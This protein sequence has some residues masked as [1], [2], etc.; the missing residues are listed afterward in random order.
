[1]DDELVNRLIEFKHNGFGIGEEQQLWLDSDETKV[2]IVAPEDRKKLYTLKATNGKRNYIRAL[3]CKPILG[4]EIDG[5]LNEKSQV[6][7]HQK[8]CRQAERL[9]ASYGDRIVPVAWGPHIHSNFGIT[10]E[11]EGVN[12][13]GFV[14]GILG[15]IKE[16]RIPLIQIDFSSTIDRAI[17]TIKIRIPSLDALHQLTRRLQSEN[18]IL[19]IRVISQQTNSD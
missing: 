8:S 13:D 19:H 14:Y 16:L 9:K 12:Q 5:I 6:E 3:C 1:M 11:I 18:D 10:L 7:V 17:G 2:P 4:E 15:T